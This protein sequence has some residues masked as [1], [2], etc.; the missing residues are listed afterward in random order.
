MRCMGD[1]R[2][3]SSESL[4]RVHIGCE[5]YGCVGT[6]CIALGLGHSAVDRESIVARTNADRASA[7]CSMTHAGTAVAPC[8]RCV[9]PVRAVGG[10]RGRLAI[11]SAQRRLRRRWR[12]RCSHLARRARACGGRVRAGC[13][14]ARGTGGRDASGRGV[15]ERRVVGRFGRGARAGRASAPD[16]WHAAA[17][18]RPAGSPP[19]GSEGAQGAGAGLG[20]HLRHRCAFWCGPLA[21]MRRL[22]G[23]VGGCT[24]AKR[25]IRVQVEVVTKQEH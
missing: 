22:H 6:A 25:G 12:S 5:G 20:C 19:A 21:C 11:N 4:E 14:R 7:R 18:R 24:E 9:C 1:L 13:A 23:N 2:C 17:A 10:R 3:D 15:S 8:R 16:A